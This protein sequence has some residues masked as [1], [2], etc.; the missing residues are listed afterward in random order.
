MNVRP[1]AW[2]KYEAV[3]LLEGMIDIK[4][5]DMPRN[6]VVERVSQDLRKMA[7]NRGIEI[8]ELFRNVN[9]IAFQLQS[10]ESAY[11]GYTVFKPASKLFTE[12]AG[13]YK[14]D[15]T[16][17]ELLLKEAKKMIAGSSS[18]ESLFFEYLA[19]KVTP[20][21]LSAL[22]PCY[23]EIEIFCTK[24]KVLQKPLFET[25]ERDV[26]Q[27][28]Q[29]TIEQNK[30]FRVTHRKQYDRILSAGRYYFDFVYEGS[31]LKKESFAV[32]EKE[33]KGSAC[34]EVK[35]T[36]TRIDEKQMVEHNSVDADAV[37]TLSFSSANNLAYTKPV[38]FVFFG[39]EKEF[40][41]NWTALYV[42]FVSSMIEKYPH[43]FRVGMSFSK[44]VGK[45]IELTEKDNSSFMIA[46]KFIPQTDYVLET[47]ISASDIAAKIRFILDWCGAD[48]EDVLIDYE[49][50]KRSS[51]RSTLKTHIAHIADDKT[52]AVEIVNS[53]AFMCYLRDE[54][55]MAEATCRSYS[56][57]INNCETFANEHGFSPWKL[58]TGDKAAAQATIAQLLE[59][60]GFLE[61][62]AKQHNRFRAALSKFVLFIGAAQ[63]TVP[64]K[65]P[66]SAEQK[67]E[68][69]TQIEEYASVLKENFGKGF[70]MESSLEIR[71]FRKYYSAINGKEL[72]D[73]DE[74]ITQNISKICLLYDGKAYLPDIMLRED[75]KKSLL[76]YIDESFA[77]GKEAVYFQALYNKFSEDF[78][79][80]HIHDADML[81]AY[82]MH[83]DLKNVFFNRNFI[84]QNA[85]VEIDPL[86]EVRDCLR[87][88]ARPM[89][90][91]EIF[92]ELSH[93]PASK[94]KFILASNSEFISNGQGTYFHESAVSLS[95]EE[96]E[97]IAAI[98]TYSIEEKEFV[99]GNE[100][101][102]AIKAKYPYIIENNNFC[103]V[104]GFRDALKY[105]LG[106]RFS[107]KGNIISRTGQELSMAD[108]F[109][110][111]AKKHDR[112]SLGEL[113]SLASELATVI[114]FEQIYENSLRISKEEFVSKNQARFAI[115]ETDAALDR[116]CAGNY[117]SIQDITNF[118]TF[119]YAGFPWN[120]FLL[121][122]Y[123]AEYSQKYMLLHSSYNGTECAGAIV[124][125]GAGLETFDDFIV[126]LLANSNIE[127][128]KASAL[129][130]LSDRGYL[131]R[132]RYS[133]IE[134]LLI[135]ANAQ[136]NRKDTD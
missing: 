130:L 121:E 14:T 97:D 57:A 113:Q 1:P 69:N 4:Q 40:E 6:I 119:P 136:R 103:S 106:N 92:S 135:Q 51:E 37:H 62:N 23:S 50:R 88:H 114:Y 76:R 77:C 18:V 123:V 13:V 32:E 109:S 96:L 125:R 115:A 38:R 10:M 58:Y 86:T 70:R 53:A 84:A 28:V 101:Y 87:E 44:N 3:I 71:R 49:K 9:G 90:Y 64:S 79:D 43:K 108:V 81:R 39:E 27:N 127:L 100:L 22:Y 133:N 59:D 102:D 72:E 33:T 94:I 65:L 89:A 25:T 17:Y 63:I 73:P 52:C 112:F 118:G 67:T 66:K 61:Y 20:A 110:N 19:S 42:C 124:K 134:S 128:N 83:L 99:G 126:D 24:A 98:I 93:L 16:S 31:F 80:S 82:L 105:K 68:E 56:S 91:E 54:L 11:C 111:Y 5:H 85:N 45:R 104:Y 7:R 26:I 78:L 15:H 117:I 30:I 131:A 12:I 132:R 29:R 120:S 122:H 55:K 129:Q 75:L 35:T 47:N 8:D 48:Y 95:T 2:D 36:L 34:P 41:P 116:V 107:F 60:D 74:L 21:Q 46:P